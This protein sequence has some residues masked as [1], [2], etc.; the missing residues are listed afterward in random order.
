MLIKYNGKIPIARDTVV[1][2][3]VFRLRNPRIVAT[4]TSWLRS[5]PNLLQMYNAF[6]LIIE[7]IGNF[8]EVHLVIG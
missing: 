4:W 2:V 6:L 1:A 7:F 5:P 8:S 3:G